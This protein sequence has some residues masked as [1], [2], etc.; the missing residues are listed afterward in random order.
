MAASLTQ[1]GFRFRNDDGDQAAATW[2]AALNTAL[3]LPADD[4]NFRLRLEITESGVGSVS[5]N[6][7]LQ[8]NR[9]FT[10]TNA[11]NATPIVITTSRAHGLTTGNTV[12]VSG[13]GGNTNAN[14]T[15]TI[16]V[17]TTTTFSLDSTTGNGAYTSG[18]I[19]VYSGGW[20]DVNATSSVIRSSA[21]SLVV[22]NVATTQQLGGGGTFG[23]GKFDEADGTFSAGTTLSD[24]TPDITEFEWCCVARSADV[25]DN[26]TIQFR[27]VTA[28]GAALGAYTQVPS[29]TTPAL[30]RLAPGA[31][32][33]WLPVSPI[34]TQW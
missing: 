15:T 19:A 9:A 18:G 5:I 13:V 24:T 27:A 3:A 12:T 32:R 8:Y 2:L 30:S 1:S 33:L 6:P 10:I 26:D 7:K 22:D 31:R 11:T 20:N 4:V 25:A 29:L 34:I 14:T 17:L 23:A 16:T 21:S 28:A